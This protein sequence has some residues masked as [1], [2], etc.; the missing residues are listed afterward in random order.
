MDAPVEFSPPPQEA[1]KWRRWKCQCCNEIYRTTHPEPEFSH[2]KCGNS[3]DLFVCLD[4]DEFT[5]K[6][7][8]WMCYNCA[9][10]TSSFE[11]PTSCKRCKATGEFECIGLSEKPRE[12]GTLMKW[13]CS[14][15]AIM[16][17]DIVPKLCLQ[18]G[19]GSS[20]FTCLG[21]ATKEDIE[22]YGDNFHDD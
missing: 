17:D 7:M 2:P 16:I 1:L 22:L 12:R 20:A 4:L 8:D 11:E 6:K 9:G 10:T 5:T 19:A 13:I 18:C 3:K 21:V 15:G 14:C